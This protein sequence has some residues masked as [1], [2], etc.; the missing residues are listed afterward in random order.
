MENKALELEWFKAK[1]SYY[2]TIKLAPKKEQRIL[3]FALF[4]YGIKGI[5]PNTAEWN[6]KARS[7]WDLIA[8]DISKERRKTI[9]KIEAKGLRN[10]SADDGDTDPMNINAVHELFICNLQTDGKTESDKIQS[11]YPKI[12]ANAILNIEE[13]FYKFLTGNKKITTISYAVYNRRFFNWMGKNDN[14]V[15]QEIKNTTAG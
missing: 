4:D 2:E 1:T 9:W 8:K 15:L 6:D 10:D 11:L 14:L 13:R 3:F 12:N 7:L 5:E